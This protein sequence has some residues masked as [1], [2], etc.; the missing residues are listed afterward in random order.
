ME[1]LN[2]N[3]KYLRSVGVNIKRS[4]LQN[5]FIAC[6]RNLDLR[7]GGGMFS[8]GC[9]SKRSHSPIYASFGEN[10]ENSERLGRQTRPRIESGTSRLSV[11]KQSLSATGGAGYLQKSYTITHW[12][13]GLVFN[14]HQLLQLDTYRSSFIPLSIFDLID[15]VLKNRFSNFSTTFKRS[16]SEKFCRHHYIND[17]VL[18]R[19]LTIP[20]ENLIMNGTLI[21]QMFI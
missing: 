12:N 21:L 17:S 16:Q 8:V 15:K 6:T 20:A 5:W 14:T 9:L 13:V 7:R 1:E 18:I 3:H 4:Y 11:W 2:T 19:N 10:Q